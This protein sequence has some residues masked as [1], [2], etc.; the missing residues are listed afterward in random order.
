MIVINDDNV[1]S[2][3]ASTAMTTMRTIARLKSRLKSEE[4]TRISNIGYVIRYWT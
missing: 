3:V 1:L 2:I 4:S